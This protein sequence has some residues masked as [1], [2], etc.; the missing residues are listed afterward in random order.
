MVHVYRIEEVGSRFYRVLEYTSDA[1]YCYREMQPP[2]KERDYPWPEWE[3]HG[4]GHPYAGPP[5]APSCVVTRDATVE[6]NLSLGIE[7]FIPHRLLHGVLPEALM[8]TLQCEF[9]QDEDF[10]IRGYPKRDVHGKALNE[11]AAGH[12]LFI[13]LAKGGHVAFHGER[14]QV[15]G[16]R[17]PATRDRPPGCLPRR[18]LREKSHLAL[19]CSSNISLISLFHLRALAG[20]QGQG[21]RAR[22]HARARAAPQALAPRAAAPRRPVRPRRARGLLRNSLTALA[23]FRGDLRDRQVDGRGALLPGEHLPQKS[24]P[25]RPSADLPL[26]FH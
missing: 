23:T 15:I 26:T 2:T 3:R 20:S 11:N 17:L 16:T 21:R 22:A 6:A 4:A 5:P 19:L 9:W 13:Q 10:H 7:T 18:A 12:V 1:R 14:F 8:S 25:P 24:P